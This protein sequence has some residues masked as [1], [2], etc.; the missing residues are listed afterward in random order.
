M[1]VKSQAGDTIIEVLI[2]LAVLGSIIT[3]GYAIA[4][5][6]L[7]GVRIA[8][9][10]GEALKIA[11]TQAEIIKQ[12]FDTKTT[13]D[14]AQLSI[15]PAPRVALNATWSVG[16]DYGICFNVLDNS[17]KK[18]N[19]PLA[20]REDISNS[21]FSGCKFGDDGRYH[22]F[23]TTDLIT[24]GD[25]PMGIESTKASLNYKIY[26][27]WERSGGGSTLETLQLTYRDNL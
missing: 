22:I 2:A 5:R 13:V 16:Q 27:M 17:P 10:R 18:I 25:S 8:Q 7:N 24:T 21:E 4:T 1:C 20:Q 19:L 11:E 23:I 15:G 26:V 6:S 9:E 14:F 12:F 3:G